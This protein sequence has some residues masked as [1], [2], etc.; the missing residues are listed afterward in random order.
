MGRRLM[1]PVIS[2][3]QCLSKGFSDRSLRSMPAACL[4]LWMRTS[5]VADASAAITFERVP[6]W[7]TP[8]FSDRPCFRL[9][10]FA[11]AAICRASSRMALCPLPGS[12]PA[13]A[14]TPFT[15][16]VYS[17][18]PLRAV[19]TAPRRPAAGSRTRTAADSLAS[20]SVIAR[21]ELLP[22]SSSETR[23][24]VTGR[25]SSPCQCFRAPI[26]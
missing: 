14:A 8:A 12:S 24:T 13:C 2:S 25:G 7:I 16:R 4:A 10:S 21:D 3:L 1:A 22:T 17:P 11:I 5:I 20:A 15:F 26:A 6:P 23:N 19:F 9:F 18:T